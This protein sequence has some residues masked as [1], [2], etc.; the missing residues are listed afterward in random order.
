MKYVRRLVWFVASRLLVIGLVLGLCVVS[1]YYAMNLTNM[2]IIIKDGMARRAQYVMG[3]ED[4]DELGKYFQ[5]GFLQTDATLLTMQ[6]GSSP[7]QD[8]NVKGIDHRI[9]MGFVWVWPW[10][11]TCRVEITES[12]PRIDGRVKAD[13]AEEIVALYGPNAV[14]P[15]TWQSARYRVTMV[16][17]NGQWK[18][19]SL[20]M[21]GNGR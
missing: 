9:D 5:S 1:F 15:P 20:A 7:Y 14:Y 2:Q 16:R 3:M 21:I 11:D 10:D 17:E 8:Y 6:N 13:R 12:I 4:A 19:R 18:I